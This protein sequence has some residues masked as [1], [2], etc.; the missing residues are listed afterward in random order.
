MRIFTVIRFVFWTAVLSVQ[1]PLMGD[2]SGKSKDEI[3]A[4]FGKPISA[5]N[6][7]KREI[8]NYPQ[9]QIVLVGGIVSSYKGAFNAGDAA[10][11]SSQPSASVSTPEPQRPAPQ[12]A[13][14]ASTPQPEERRSIQPAGTATLTCYLI[15]YIVYAGVIALSI[16]LP[17]SLRTETVGLLKSLC[18]AFAIVWVTGL[19]NRLGI[20]LKI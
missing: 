20:K 13:P 14:P 18:F 15:P 1:F 11:P 8:L 2:I 9:G 4:S 19:I 12:T 5:L 17:E 3:L 16:T 10:A 7:S 6:S